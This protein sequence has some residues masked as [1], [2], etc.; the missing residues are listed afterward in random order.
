MKYLVAQDW[1]NTHGN[2]A[3]MVHMCDLLVEKYPDEY[4]KICNPI[5]SRAFGLEVF[6]N[7]LRDKIIRTFLPAIW[8]SKK[9][10]YYKPMLEK[11]KTGD[12]VF[13]L[14]YCSGT[15]SQDILARYIRKHNE[16]VK[17]FAMSHLAKSV[18]MEQGFDAE[19]ILKWDSYVDKHI[20][21]GSSLA[22][23]FLEC[24]VSPNKISTGFHY[25]DNEYYHKTEAEIII[26]KKPTIIAIGALQRDFRLLAEIVNNTK[27]VDWIICR[28]LKP[29]DHLFH[30]DNIRLVGF[31]PE[32]ELRALMAEAD[33]SI[34][35]L[36]DTV[37]SNVITTSLAM[38]LVVIVSDVGS[39]RDYVDS[40]CALFCQNNAD[41]FIKTIIGFSSDPQRI[42][43]MR[44]A[45][46]RKVPNLTVEKVH[47]WFCSL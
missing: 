25:V 21:M 18:Y 36:E 4:I 14:Q 17:L 9:L 2:H 37:G 39:I 5:Q 23:Y 41:S 6:F 40:S 15:A 42:V 38:G 27:S 1:E 47:N 24:G 32:A 30:G 19:E 44:R 3:G 29:V 13:L 10:K 11:L 16:G 46:L 45:A 12:I 26:K 34:N 31:V 35:V 28:G 33:A 8:N 7:R 22:N 43:E 20:L